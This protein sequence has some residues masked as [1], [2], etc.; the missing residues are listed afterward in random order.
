MLAGVFPEGQEAKSGGNLLTGRCGRE[1]FRV[2][3]GKHGLA[4][5]WG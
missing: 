3:Y 2:L 4:T 1:E 5:S